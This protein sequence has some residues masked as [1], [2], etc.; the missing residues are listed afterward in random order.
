MGH[1][2]CADSA[3]CRATLGGADGF[4]TALCYTFS[5]ISTGGFTTTNSGLTE[6]GTLYVKIVL[7]VFMFLG[8]VS[9]SLMFRWWNGDHG[10]LWRNDVFRAYVRIILVCLMLFIITILAIGAYTGIESVSIDPLF[11]I[12]STL[13]STGFMVEGARNWGP[14]VISLLFVL[15]FSGHAPGAPAEEQK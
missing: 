8:G 5:T 9:F 7:T 11:Q 15:M 6:Y 2:L 12:I 13:T 10:S 14:F 4:Y 3:A 1:I